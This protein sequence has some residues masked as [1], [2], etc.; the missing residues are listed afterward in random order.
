LATLDDQVQWLQQA[1]IKAILTLTRNEELMQAEEQAVLT[2]EATAQ[3][4]AVSYPTVRRLMSSHRLQV[5]RVGRSVRI[6][7]A[8]VARYIAEHQSPTA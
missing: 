6:P 1:G 3:V 2:V 4:L 8:A 7:V 5:V